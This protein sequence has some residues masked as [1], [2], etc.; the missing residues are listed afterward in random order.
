MQT[1]EPYV[2]PAGGAP[3]RG[4]GPVSLLAVVLLRLG[5]PLLERL[6]LKRSTQM[7]LLELLPLD[8]HHKVALVR[9]R[10][11]EI[12]LGLAQGH[13]AP[14]GEWQAEEEENSLTAT[15]GAEEERGET[16]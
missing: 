16:Q 4:P 12:L 2:E 8:R 7:Q 14:L 13:V 6:R 9:V 3:Q 11:K 15:T 5:A 1:V 10:E